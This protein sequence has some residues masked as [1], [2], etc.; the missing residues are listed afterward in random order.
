MSSEHKALAQLLH[1]VVTM[2]NRLPAKDATQ[3][4]KLVNTL[5]EQ[6]LQETVSPTALPDA[7]G[8]FSLWLQQAGSL[9]PQVPSAVTPQEGER[10]QEPEYHYTAKEL[11][12]ELAELR[13]HMREEFAKLRHEMHHRH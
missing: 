6:L 11:Y 2:L 4:D 7:I 12:F 13:L 9:M 10:P 8:R 3:T 1:S 5:Y